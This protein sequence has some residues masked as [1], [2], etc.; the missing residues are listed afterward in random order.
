MSSALSSLFAARLIFLAA[1]A[2]VAALLW[3][4]FRQEGGGE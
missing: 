4:A 2:A 3:W 1:L